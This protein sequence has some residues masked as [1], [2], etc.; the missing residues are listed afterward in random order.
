MLRHSLTVSAVYVF[1]Y[2]AVFVVG[3]LGNV[4]VVLIVLRS[5]RM[6]NATNFFI[7]NLAL[8]DIL[9]LLCCLP[10]TLIG[11]LFLRK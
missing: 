6:R 5:P 3:L 4:C 8:A 1:A 10:A 9:V 2:S 7:C 11:N